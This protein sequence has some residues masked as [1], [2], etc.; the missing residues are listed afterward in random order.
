MSRMGVISALAA[1]FVG[2]EV[3]GERILAGI[4]TL[5]GSAADNLP[6]I[7]AVEKLGSIALF[8]R[9]VGF[10]RFIRRGFR[11]DAAGRDLVV[12]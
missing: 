10:S 2:H 6:F 8:A 7:L 5:G 4:Y 11:K 12:G 1:V 3:L 9:F